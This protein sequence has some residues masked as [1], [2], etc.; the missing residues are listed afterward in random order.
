[1]TKNALFLALILVALALPAQTG[2]GDAEPV[3]DCPDGFQLHPVGHCGC[4]GGGHGDGGHGDGGHSDHIH[5]GIDS[6]R[7][8]DGW[9]CMKHV[10]VDGGVH[11]HIDDFGKGNSND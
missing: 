1:M 6:D 11:V 10:G 9:I 4:G 2:H 7:N 8:G 5:A 3:R